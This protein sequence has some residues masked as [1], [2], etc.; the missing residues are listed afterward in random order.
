MEG[1]GREVEKRRWKLTGGRMMTHA[2]DSKGNRISTDLRGMLIIDRERRDPW[3]LRFF[4][5]FLLL[6]RAPCA[7]CL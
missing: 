1:G 5:F 6:L 3:I 7:G 2:I 4:F